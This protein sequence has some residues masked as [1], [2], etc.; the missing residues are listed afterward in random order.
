VRQTLIAFAG[1][2]RPLVATRT[3]LASHCTVFG[4]T[5]PTTRYFHSF[6]VFFVAA[7]V[8]D[9]SLSNISQY[10]FEVTFILI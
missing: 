6:V 9:L 2:D 10:I 5:H 7:N 4:N 3:P 8:S 1:R